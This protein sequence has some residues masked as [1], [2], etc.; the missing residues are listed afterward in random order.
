MKI[1]VPNRVVRSY[2]QHLAAPPQA[3]FPLL[4][5]VREAGRVPGRAPARVVPGPAR[6]R[7]RG[8]GIGVG[9]IGAAVGVQRGTTKPV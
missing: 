1:V 6:A 4:C 2:T 9:L 5:P 3:V 7:R 8:A